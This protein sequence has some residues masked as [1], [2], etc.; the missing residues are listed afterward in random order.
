M[1]KFISLLFLGILVSGCY[2]SSL[3]YV[4]PATGGIANGKAAQSFATTS[5]SYLIKEKTGKTPM[6]HLLTKEQ[7]NTV[8]KQKDK[9]N[10]CKKNFE[11]CSTI[12][13]RIENT[14]AKILLQ[15]KMQE[16]KGKISS[17]S[18]DNSVSL[19]K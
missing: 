4:A 7:I 18:P 1:K 3:T 5:A 14:R 9:L 10:P 17:L 13:A 19:N 11:F 16:T 12:K 6:E 2:Q 15:K 8:D